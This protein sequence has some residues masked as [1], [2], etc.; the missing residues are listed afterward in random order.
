LFSE[1]ADLSEL[2]ILYEYRVYRYIFLLTTKVIW[3]NSCDIDF[4][5]LG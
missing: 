1:Y 4:S 2:D 5:F 3:Y